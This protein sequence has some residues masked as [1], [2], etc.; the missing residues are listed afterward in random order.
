MLA[1]LSKALSGWKLG[2]SSTH[3]SASVRER[4]SA[5]IMERVAARPLGVSGEVAGEVDRGTS[6][7]VACGVE[8]II[9]VGVGVGDRVH[10]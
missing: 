10:R 7:P 8:I 4:E 1:P 2:S 6:E 3:S 9:L 5:A